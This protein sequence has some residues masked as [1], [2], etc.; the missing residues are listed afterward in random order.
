MAI[1]CVSMA[2]AVSKR[3]SL[4]S[5]ERET[6]RGVLLVWHRCIM[7][8]CSLLPLVADLCQRLKGLLGSFLTGGGKAAS[9]PGEFSV[10]PNIILAD[11]EVEA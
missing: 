10:T 1:E 5:R 9:S 8:C 4:E 2:A 3:L 11:T 6:S 7:S